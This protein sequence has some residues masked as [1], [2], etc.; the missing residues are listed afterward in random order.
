MPRGVVVR[1]VDYLDEAGLREAYA[2]NLDGR[3]LV[4]PDVVDD[5]ARLASFGAASLD[6]IIANHM[7]EHVEDP[8]AA[9]EQHHRVL[10]PGG[11]LYMA[12]PDARSTFDA[13][14]PRTTPEHLV[15]D[16]R[17]GP[18]VSRLQHYEECARLIEGHTDETIEDRVREMEATGMRPHFHVWEPG[19]FP[20]LLGVL[21]VA[22]SLELIQA[23]HDEFVVVLR[24]S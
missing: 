15:R 20:G 19:T 18:E 4:I 7:L 17:E 2:A 1:Y 5:G 23:S 13:P 16:H 12:L 8:I 22:F 3:R 11:I 6:F 9:L 14:R 21:T 10:K 24:K